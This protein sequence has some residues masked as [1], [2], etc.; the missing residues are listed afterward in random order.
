MIMATF[1]GLDWIVVSAVEISSN[2]GLARS[3]IDAASKCNLG[4]LT[5]WLLDRTKVNRHTPLMT[6]EV[7]A[8]LLKVDAERVPDTSRV[9]RNQ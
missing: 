9:A 3:D 1:R 6:K 7:H 8:L 4:S 2:C 5:Q